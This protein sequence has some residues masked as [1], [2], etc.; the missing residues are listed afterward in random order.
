MF[1][2]SIARVARLRRPAGFTAG[3]VGALVFSASLS[4]AQTPATQAPSSTTP[5]P[6]A[7]SPVTTLPG[8]A[9]ELTETHGDWRVICGQQ[10]SARA[11][12]LSQQQMKPDSRQ[13]VLGVE[14]KTNAPEKAEGTLVLPFGIAV[15]KPVNLQV[16][17]AGTPLT[18]HVRTCVPIGCVVPL[19]LDTPLVRSLKNGKIWTVKMTADGGEELALKVSLNG[20]GSA[21]DRTAALSK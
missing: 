1:E 12:S 11:C 14:L 3:V 4:S 20:F 5:H 18:T 13:L 8:G 15:D 2:Q 17:D 6:A 10:N 19:T 16:D 21:L 7:A 9:S